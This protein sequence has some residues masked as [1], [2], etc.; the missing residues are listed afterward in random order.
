MHDCFDLT[1]RRGGHEGEGRAVSDQKFRTDRRRS[2]TRDSLGLTDSRIRISKARK[3]E[4]NS[5]PTAR[6][7]RGPDLYGE[8]DSEPFQVKRP[9]NP[10]CCAGLFAFGT[11]Y[12][13]IFQRGYFESSVHFFKRKSKN[14]IN[15]RNTRHQCS[16]KHGYLGEHNNIA[17]RIW[18]LPSLIIT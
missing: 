14:M 9:T 2:M 7:V 13:I 17:A 1:K 18:L 4:S 8:R 15:A 5:A 6:A 16:W 11:L 12:C 3:H 10:P